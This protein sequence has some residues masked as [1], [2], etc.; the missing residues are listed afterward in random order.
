MTYKKTMNYL[1]HLQSHGIRPGLE[2]ME[3][4]LSLLD[5]PERSFR[6]IHIGGTNGKG[7]TAEMTASVL[8]ECGYRVG[9]YTSP[10]LIHFSERIRICGLPIP[11]DEIVRLTDTISHKIASNAPSLLHDITF[12][13]FTTALAFLY[14]SESRIDLAV[15]EVGMGGQFDATNLLKPLVTVIT[16]IDLDHEQYLGHTLL[17]IAAEK[18]GII[19]ESI[20]VI[21]GAN[22]E[23]VC[24]R[25]EQIAYSKHAPLFRL[26]KEIRISSKRPSSSLPWHS[27]TEFSY[28]G[29]DDYQI[30][31]PLLGRHQINNASVAIA[32]TELLKHQGF[33]ISESNIVEGIRNTHLSGRLE[34]IQTHPLILLDGAHNPSG[35]RA[36][37]IYLDEMEHNLRG[38]CWLIFGAMRDKKIDEILKP[39]LP[40]TNEIVITRPEIARA[41]APD[42]IAETLGMESTKNEIHK[43][44]RI[45][46]REKVA[47]AISYVESR[48]HPRDRLVIT[49]SLFTVGEAKAIFVGASPSLIR[50]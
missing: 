30:E 36:L 16:Q 29:F 4:L 2:R 21:I 8:I 37:G 47:D 6:S 18:A 26:G 7:S 48:I 24:K 32:C 15:V 28:S 42:V 19:K 38:K 23:E 13:E 44:L 35:A 49:G 40:S 27:A 12:F 45:T 11:D 3:S 43:D 50:G 39:L 10:H 22:Q 20:P 41:A 17:E 9:L 34:V 5:H 25:F 1:Y 31:L 33:S 14:F 46:I